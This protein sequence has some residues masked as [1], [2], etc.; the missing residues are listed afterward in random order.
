MS[1][2]DFVRYSAGC[3]PDDWSSCVGLD[4]FVPETSLEVVLAKNRPVLLSEIHPGGV[5]VLM[6]C[7]VDLAPQTRPS[8][9]KLR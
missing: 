7:A 6:T 3:F 2:T 1:I 5:D 8:C 9:L 4:E